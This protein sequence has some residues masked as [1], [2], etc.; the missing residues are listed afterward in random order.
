MGQVISTLLASK[1]LASKPHLRAR[2]RTVLLGILD[3][4]VEAKKLH[5][6][7]VSVE[8]PISTRVNGH[9]VWYGLDLD[10]RVATILVVEPG[11]DMRTNPA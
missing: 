8:P 1:Q 9:V 10:L 5:G 3:T 2:I 7:L 4:A 11:A 6:E